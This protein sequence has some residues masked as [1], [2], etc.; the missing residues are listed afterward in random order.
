M[1]TDIGITLW[2]SPCLCFFIE[3]EPFVNSQ[4]SQFWFKI[5]ELFF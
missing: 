4:G 5:Q 1:V 2:K 3:P